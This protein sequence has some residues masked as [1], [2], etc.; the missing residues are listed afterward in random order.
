MRARS[1]RS[2]SAP[3]LTSERWCSAAAWSRSPACRC[4]ARGSSSPSRSRPLGHGC[5]DR[6]RFLVADVSRLEAL[7]DSRAGSWS[8]EA[9]D[10]KDCDDVVAPRAAYGG[11]QDRPPRG[12]SPARGSELGRCVGQLSAPDRP[13]AEPLP[14][15]FSDVRCAVR[16]LRT[17][18]TELGRHPARVVA[19]GDS[20]GASSSSCSG[21]PRTQ[22]RSTTANASSR[23]PSRSTR[24]SPNTVA[25]KARRRQRRLLFH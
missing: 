9:D 6:Q 7:P 4:R 11:G 10:K 18:A 19:L 3:A 8:R 21:S 22:R 20:G 15:A 14:A 13:L 24:S 16:W 25:R 1:S 5:D 2:H 17:H 23:G 12:H